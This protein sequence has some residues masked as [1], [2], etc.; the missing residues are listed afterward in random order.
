MKKFLFI[1]LALP[2]MLVSCNGDD[3]FPKID[4]SVDMSGGKVLNNV[5]YVVS[6]DTLQVDSVNVKSRE[7]K[8]VMIGGVT[9]FWD[10]APVFTSNVV[11]FA[12]IF[13]TGNMPLGN[14]LLQ[15]DCAVYAVD[16]APISALMK[17]KVKVVESAEDIPAEAK[18]LL[19]NKIK[20]D[21]DYDD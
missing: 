17:F 13:P 4:F 16:Y 2:V 9:Y 1:L 5:I 8:D 3:D 6:G 7:N 20:P 18:P 19:F 14:H 11:P 12:S 10:Y 21:V 15:L